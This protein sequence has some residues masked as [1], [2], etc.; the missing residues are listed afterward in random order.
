MKHESN[1]RSQLSVVVLAMAL[2]GLGFGQSEYVVKAH[3]TKEGQS[4]Q[5]KTFGTGWWFGKEDR[6]P[7]R[8]YFDMNEKSGVPG[9]FKVDLP[10]SEKT[11]P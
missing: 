3:P 9:A 1:R 2:V 6:I 11:E 5:T 8:I 10:E 7:K 4:V